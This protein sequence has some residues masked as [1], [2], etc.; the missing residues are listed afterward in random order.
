MLGV[1]RFGASHQCCRG[2]AASRARLPPNPFLFS[3]FEEACTSGQASRMEPAAIYGGN[4]SGKTNFF[5]A[6]AFAKGVLLAT[7]R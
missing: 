1:A 5:R 7:S 6:L 2:M 3:A 4:A